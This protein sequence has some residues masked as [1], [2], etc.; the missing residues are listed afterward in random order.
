MPPV[1]PNYPTMPQMN[2]NGQFDPGLVTP[3][4]NDL[5]RSGTAYR[6]QRFINDGGMDNFNKMRGQYNADVAMNPFTYQQQTMGSYQNFM[7]D[8]SLGGGYK[9]QMDAAYGRMNDPRYMNSLQNQAMGNTG[10]M[11]DLYNMAGNKGS[12]VLQQAN[13]QRQAAMRDIAMQ[14]SM[15]QGAQY[16]PALART[17]LMQ[18]AS[19]GQNMAAQVAAA[20]AQERQQALMNYAQA[21]QA[22]QGIYGQ[23]LGQNYG[24]AN[25]LYTGAQNAWGAMN[26]IGLQ[27]HAQQT[28]AVNQNANLGKQ[29]GR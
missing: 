6:T 10:Y 24:A 23:Q 20:R 7:N 19:M 16:N 2:N 13:A 9:Q 22:A 4:Y 21:R 1:Y 28:S 14:S 26:D 8:P 25:Q 5:L 12:V 27:A 11:K 18:Q 15:Q 17:A 29:V 3:Q